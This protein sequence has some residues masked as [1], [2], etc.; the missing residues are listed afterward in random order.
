MRNLER[1]RKIYQGQEHTYI[2]HVLKEAGGKT[3]GCGH[4]GSSFISTDSLEFGH[5]GLVL[6][7][8]GGGTAL[9]SQTGVGSFD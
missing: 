7:S 3:R 9:A 5:A 8:R 4:F 2:Y 6:L 1:G